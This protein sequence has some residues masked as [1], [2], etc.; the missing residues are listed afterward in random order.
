MSWSGSGHYAA[1]TVFI[2]SSFTAPE[3]VDVRYA[4]HAVDT[5][6]LGDISIL[7]HE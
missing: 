3:G 6:F 5:L 4:S 2:G 1:N 7:A